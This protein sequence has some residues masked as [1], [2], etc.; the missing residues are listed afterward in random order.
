MR[1][2][3][4]HTTADHPTA[5]AR[6]GAPPESH[7]PGLQRVAG[8]ANSRSADWV[9][10]GQGVPPESGARRE[11]LHLTKASVGLTS[12][13]VWLLHAARSRQAHRPIHLRPHS[14]RLGLQRSL[15]A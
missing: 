15:A 14:K 1:E 6:V 13:N 10:G 3:P 2:S 12:M 9:V 8:A 5:A 7:G 11:P 4:G